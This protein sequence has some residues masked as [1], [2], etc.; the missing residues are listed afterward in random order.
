MKIFYR[1]KVKALPVVS[2]VQVVV[3]SKEQ[4]FLFFEKQLHEHSG[5]HEI[6]VLSSLF[7]SSISVNRPKFASVH[8]QAIFITTRK[9]NGAD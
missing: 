3:H 8:I 2:R 7:C 4:S 1:A 6:P 5:K 9:Y